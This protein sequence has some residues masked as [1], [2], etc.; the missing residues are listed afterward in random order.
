MRRISRRTR[1]SLLLGERRGSVV[2]LAGCSILAGFAES[3]TLAV[4]AQVATS[5]VKGSKHL[6]A[7]IGPVHVDTSLGTLV[8]VAFVLTF[9]RVALAV[10]LSILPARIASTVQTH[11]RIKLF[12]AYT[13][14]SWAVQSRDR[15]GQLQETMTGQVMQAAS[16]AQQATMLINTSF[17][18]LVLVGT[19]FALNPLAAVIIAGTTVVM[20][21]V[22]RPL[23]QRVMSSSRDLSRAQVEYAGGVAESIRLAEETHVF[24]VVDRQRQRMA[25]WAEIYNELLYR[26]GVLTRLAGKLYEGLIVVLLVAGVAVLYW[27]GGGH[28]A[29]LGGVILLLVRAGS[30]GQGVQ[31]AY[32]GLGQ[33]MPFIER[34]Q[35]TLRSYAESAPKDGEEALSRVDSLAFE[36]V[37]FAYSPGQEVL[38]EIS[39]NVDAGEVIG[40]IGPSGA[41][42]S[43]IVQLLLQLRTPVAGRYLI[44]GAPADVFARADW[45]R[46]VS[47]VPQEPRLLHASVEENIRFFRDIEDVDVERAARLARIHDDITSWSDGYQTIVG[48]RADAVSGGQQQ[49]ICLA[50]ALAAHPEVLVLDEPTSALDPQSETL[51]GESLTALKH[52]LTLFIIAHRMSTLDICDRVMVIVDGRLVAFD[53]K[54]LLERDSPYYRDASRLAAGSTGAWSSRLTKPGL[55]SPQGSRDD[56]TMV[57]DQRLVQHGPRTPDFFIVGAPKSG[58]TALY[59]MLRE[60]PQIFMPDCKELWFFADELHVRTPP[61][62]EGT[63]QTLDEYLSWFTPAQPGQRAG[64]ATALYLWSQTAARRIAD[65]RPDARMIAILREPASFLHSLH[66]QFVQTHVETETDLRKALDLENAR[67]QGRSVP[68]NTYWPQALLYSDHVR[69]A[70]QLQRYWDRFSPE[71]MLV[72]IY[73]DFRSDNAA[74]VR[75]VLRFLE[76]DESIAIDVRDVNSTVRVRSRRANELVHAVTVG[77]GPASSTLKSVAGTLTP[78]RLRRRMLQAAKSRLLF[79]APDPPDEA[80]MQELRLRCKPEVVALSE[81]LGRD[82]VT[83]WGYD[84]V[85]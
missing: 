18:F 65:L 41:G 70:E 21:G 69:Y 71:Q 33:S 30:A 68:Q 7:H 57:S 13:H 46:Q 59:E 36:N 12:D 53:T 10:P 37:S 42:K 11:M 85:A 8:D 83:L 63:P 45:N 6:N 51:I 67:R 20:F 34:T 55:T 23:R 81:A 35:D 1:L 50:R 28:A 74:T 54:A 84:S 31:A 66:L 27:T 75:Q 25:H 56:A 17:S 47:Y 40:I 39:F 2:A 82:L 24:G 44:N 38:S 78:Q 61:R 43:T 79:T 3:G 16:G 49:R 26:T 64:E 19:A 58:T 77:R 72:L 52:E 4:I 5:L 14:A 32:Q 62:P 80:L 60:H 29:S 9:V 76:V 15:E 48:P 73:D 22:L